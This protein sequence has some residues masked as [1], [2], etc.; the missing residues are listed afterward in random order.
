MENRQYFYLPGRGLVIYHIHPDIANKSAGDFSGIKNYINAGHPQMCYIVDASSSFEYPTG[1]PSS[2]GSVFEGAEFPG[3]SSSPNIFFTS[4]S[5]PSNVG[6]DGQYPQDKDVAFI[7]EDGENIKFIFNPSISGPST[8]CEQ[9]TYSIPD[10]PDM[11]GQTG[12]EWSDGSIVRPDPLPVLF[13]EGQGTETISVVRNGEYVKDPATGEFFPRYFHSGIMNITAKVSCGNDSYTMTKRVNM[14][15]QQDLRIQSDDYDGLSPIRY[16]GGST[17]NLSLVEPAENP[18]HIKWVCDFDFDDNLEGIP[19]DADY[20]ETYYGNSVSIPTYPVFGGTLT[21]SAYDIGDECTPDR[22]GTWS[23]HIIPTI[24]YI[25]HTNPASGSVDISLSRVPAES[26]GSGVAPLSA[27][28]VQNEP[29]TGAYRLELWHDHYG[30][31]RSLDVS[32]NRPSV[33]LDLNGLV[34][35]VYYIRLLIDGE[36]NGVSKLM[37]R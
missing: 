31:V 17:V 2:Y 35:G 29:Y 21:V 6:W 16:M 3:S 26:D 25:S 4:T 14:P 12:I 13:G 32:G 10:V 37:V 36:I 27:A 7:H 30:M 22:H 9:G 34:P 1:G 33:T 19:A 20:T 5:T 28:P 18:S 11:S 8:L 15:A 24:I 23:Q